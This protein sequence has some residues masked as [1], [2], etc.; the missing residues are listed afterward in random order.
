M[1]SLSGLVADEVR[2]VLVDSVLQSFRS[3][4]DVRTV[5]VAQVCCFSE[6]LLLVLS[7][8]ANGFL[9]K[10]VARKDLQENKQTQNK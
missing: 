1:S 2:D 9:L 8:V 6:K 7:S 10:R 3:S 4:A 5:A